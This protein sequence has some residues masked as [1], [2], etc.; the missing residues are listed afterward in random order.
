MKAGPVTCCQRKVKTLGIH[1]VLLL[2]WSFF[3]T[4]SAMGVMDL[5]A[6]PL[7][8][9][10]FKASVLVAEIALYWMEA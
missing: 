5:S 2:F 1:T 4:P 9:L 6:F 3:A 8:P 10:M 7:L